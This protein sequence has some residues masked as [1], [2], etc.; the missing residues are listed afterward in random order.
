MVKSIGNFARYFKCVCTAYPYL[1]RSDA[2]SL[3]DKSLAILGIRKHFFEIMRL[4]RF[5]WSTSRHAWMY[6]LKRQRF[7]DRA[8]G[9]RLGI[10]QRTV[11]EYIV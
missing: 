11:K 9:K 2:R 1:L 8:I 5:R 3:P 6:G 10:D 4:R 7:S